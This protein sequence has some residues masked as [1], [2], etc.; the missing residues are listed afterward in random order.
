VN[1]RREEIRH[2]VLLEMLGTWIGSQIPN[3]VHCTFT[4]V[5]SCNVWPIHMEITHVTVQIQYVQ[6]VGLTSESFTINDGQVAVVT[7][8]RRV[9]EISKQKCMDRS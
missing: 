5:F 7:A 2:K 4:H 8:L 6:I 1:P 9:D 3:M